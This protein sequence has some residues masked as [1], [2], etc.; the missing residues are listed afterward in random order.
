[1]NLLYHGSG[2]KQ[3]ELMPGYYRSGNLVE[4]DETESNKFLYVTTDRE[5]AIGQGFASTVEKVFKVHRYH[6]DGMNIEIEIDK[7]P[8]PTRSDLEKIEI[9][10]YTIEMKPADGWVK[11]NNKHN[12]LDTEY[13]SE[14]TISRAII[15]CEKVDMK[16]WLEHR[17]VTVSR[18]KPNWARWA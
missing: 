17:H 14:E 11:V 16:K 4:W 12:G 9:Y 3:T 15:D 7:G 6:E 1:M 13:K 10:L 18:V 2:F 5:V 8:L